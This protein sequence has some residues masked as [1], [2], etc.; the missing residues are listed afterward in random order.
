MSRLG[1]EC[2]FG[3]SLLCRQS[4]AIESKATTATTTITTATDLSK[5]VRY[6]LVIFLE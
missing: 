3:F 4:K 2:S 6:C 1:N 5:F